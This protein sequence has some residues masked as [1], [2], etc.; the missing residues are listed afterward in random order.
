MIE[1]GL[2]DPLLE[3]LRCAGQNLS[4]AREGDTVLYRAN[5]MIYQASIVGDNVV[6]ASVLVRGDEVAEIHW[7]FWGPADRAHLSINPLLVSL[8]RCEIP[9]YENTV[10]GTYRERSPHRSNLQGQT[11]QN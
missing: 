10:L 2:R 3:G 9:E 8:A 1:V 5:G 11:A 4:V 6:N 7:V